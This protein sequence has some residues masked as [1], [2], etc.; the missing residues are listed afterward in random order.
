MGHAFLVPSNLL[1]RNSDL[2][3]NN[4]IQ[5]DARIKHSHGRIANLFLDLFSGCDALINES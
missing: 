2:K 3:T 5:T 4:K 1:H